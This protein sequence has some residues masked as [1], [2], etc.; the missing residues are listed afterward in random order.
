MQTTTELKDRIQ[1]NTRAAQ[2]LLA[3]KGSA[4][5]L[6]KD[7]A[8]FDRLLDDAERAQERL[9]MVL[10]ATG[11]TDVIAASHREG[12]EIFLRKSFQA[13]SDAE[14]RKVRNTM[15]TTTGSQGGYAVPTLVAGEVINLIK[16]YK[17]MRTVASKLTTDGGNDLGYPTSDG[18]SETG[19]QLAQ[20]ASASSSDPSLGTVPV[21]T[22]IYGSK[23][24]AVPMELLQDAQ[25][26]IVAFV[27]Q[28]LAER[29]GRIQ[30]TKFTIGTGSGEPNGL[31][32]AATVGKTGTTGQ[33][34]TI[35]YDDMAD[36]AESV[37][38]AQTE[39]GWMMSQSMRKVV[40][41]L[42][43][44]SG[45]P[46]WVPALTDTGRPML[47]E[48]PVYIN[49]DMPVPAANAKSLAFGNLASY[50]VRDT[51]QVTFFRFDDSPYRSKAQV[52]FLA[53]ARAGGN[54]LDS[55]A[56]RVYQHSAT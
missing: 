33:T 38:E 16:G 43:D 29:I 31:V 17:G 1:V 32:T 20:N 50:L 54:L 21:P 46:I 42:K 41:K 48:Y 14:R 36:L 7:Q 37:D 28:R 9:D 11:Q 13:M 40:R 52:G 6:P 51:L 2:N 30:N 44:T 22:Y 26:D 10:N 4:I 34:L 23:I 39:P 49:N 3:D 45:R 27:T 56:V 55:G 18:T 12:L 19:E 15:S 25:V 47:M 24:I 5:W 35:L 53:R 8:A